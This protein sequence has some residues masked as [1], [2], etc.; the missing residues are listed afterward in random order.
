MPKE[1]KFCLLYRDMWQSSGKY[2]PKVDQLVKVA[3]PIIKMHCWD[4]VE[5]N[6]GGFE[7][8]QL[9]AGEN[10]NKAVREWTQPFNDS[11]IQTQMLERGLN[12][13]SMHPVSKDIRELMYVVKKKQGT[14][15]SRSFDGLNDIRNLELSI[16]YAK[17]A[18]M[19]SQS[20]LCIT[21]S[22]IHSIKYYIDLAKELIK[23]GTDEIAIKD[24]AGIGRPSSLGKIVKG[25]K[26]FSSNTLVQYH[27]HSAPG[28]SVASSLEVA[29]AGA[30]IIDVS[31][32]PLSWGTTHADLLTIYEVLKDDGFLLKDI[33]MKSYM[34]VKNLTQEF[35]DE[36]LG[37]YI[38]PKNRYMNSLLIESGLP[39]G[40]MGSLMNDLEKSL[41]SV[42]KWLLKN[43]KDEISIDY[44]FSLL[45]DEVKLIWPILG[46]PPLV[47]PYSQYVKN[48]ALGNIIQNI[49][50][51]EKWSLIDDNTWDMLLG[52]SG[53]LPGKLGDEIITLSNK[54]NKTFYK[55]NPQD[56]FE[57]T[58]EKNK[59]EM[60]ALSWD[61]GKDNEELLEYSL[62]KTQYIDFK[63]GKAKRNFEK[64]VLRKKSDKKHDHIPKFSNP[65]I[66][67]ILE[68][69]NE[70]YE[71]EYNIENDES[72][73]NSVHGNGEKMLSPIEGRIFLTKESNDVPIKVNDIVNKGDVLCYIESM[74]VINAIKSEYSG[75]IVQICFNDGDEI[76]DDDV[77]FLID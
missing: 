44:L 45:L 33:N 53:K 43:S 28:F 75:R 38:N 8:I 14:D 12:A 5:T 37:Y 58:L 31:M 2:M 20:C 72:S 40:M 21:H 52:K 16:K 11:G 3:E 18:G 50:G 13:L 70:K 6:G 1:I 54:L 55:K 48:V 30:D 9:L 36:Y 56:L 64:D 10:P 73:S 63:S 62:H 46:Y 76:Y 17:S 22:E 69:N 39:G 77:L 24:M 25:I 68:I 60:N 19:I 49:K 35:I 15:I 42:N 41:K 61:F 26:L 29:R 74:K 32:D 23:M 67:E 66:V 27:G 57:N 59:D 71:I 47:T 65:K 34:D 51:K 7:Q 4:R